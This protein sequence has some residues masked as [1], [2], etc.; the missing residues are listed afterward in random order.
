[1]TKILKIHTCRQCGHSWANRNG[2]YPKICPN[3]KCHSMYWDEPKRK[4]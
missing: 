4:R 2:R 3:K 1:M